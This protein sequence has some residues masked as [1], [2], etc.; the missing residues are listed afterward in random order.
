MVAQ[1]LHQARADGIARADVE[2]PLCGA[3]HQRNPAIGLYHD[4]PVFHRVQHRSQ[5]TA[6]RRHV[7][8]HPPYCVCHAVESHRE[9][10]RLVRGC[11]GYAVLKVSLCEPVRSLGN[12]AHGARCAAEEKVTRADRQRA[13]QHCGN[14]D[15]CYEAIDVGLHLRQWHGDAHSRGNAIF[16]RYGRDGVQ[17][18]SIEISVKGRTGAD[19]A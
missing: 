14:D 9:F 5:L 7:A 12:R 18:F 17:H 11:T 1:H 19:A 3:V 4:H 8:Q 2:K 13:D 6:L 15:T 10:L 16:A